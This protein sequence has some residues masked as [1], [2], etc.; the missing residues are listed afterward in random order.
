MRTKGIR[1]ANCCSIQLSSGP[2]VS[3]QILFFMCSWAALVCLGMFCPHAEP[4]SSAQDYGPT[5]AAQN[6]FRIADAELRRKR[7]DQAERELDS[8][9]S[10]EALSS[11][12][13]FNLGWLYGRAHNFKK[14]LSEFNRVGQD[15]PNPR[16]H[17]YAIALAQFEL[18][19]YRAA[20][21]TLTNSTESQDLSEESANLLAVSYSKLGLY[22]E[23]YTVLRGEL[24]LHPDDRMAYLNLV[25]LLCE[26]GK[27]TNAVEVADKAVSFF[28]RDAE[29]LVVRGA[30]QILAGESAKARADFQA[31]I[32]ASPLYGP[33][34][35]LLA[36]SEYKEGNY[37]VAC[38]EIS[39][40]LKA[41]VK[42]SDLYYLLA[43][44]MLRIDPSNAER[45]IAELNRAIKANPRQ[46]QALS[47]RGKLRLQQHDLNDAVSDL[48]LAHKIDPASPSATYNLARAYFALGKTEE[49]AKLS[50][51]LASSGRDAVSEL[52]DQK[53]KRTLG[54]QS[55]DEN[56]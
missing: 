50:K 12:D 20:I 32:K 24:H 41:G 53:L 3:R 55:G 2:N 38:N 25:T 45:A 1:Q 16:T 14:A 11:V 46:V 37:E 33:P 19:N 8:L 56:R 51:Q 7:Y 48:E 6:V 40:A 44:A 29:I 15:V 23:S 21:E 22:P 4:S 39:H 52:S 27:L 36:V 26:E 35:F 43:E 31:A 13:I 49:A 34:R 5:C 10:C 30:A 47:L 18:E 54:L 9:R 17:Q 28:P 42:D